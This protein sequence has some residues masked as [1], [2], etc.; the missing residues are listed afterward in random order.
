LSFSD[1]C[2]ELLSKVPSGQITTYKAIATALNSKAYRAVGTVMAKNKNLI[3]VPCH[4]VINN[5]GK[6]GQYALGI[7]KK[8][9]LLENEGIRIR[10]GK[11]EEFEKHLYSF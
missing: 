1:D 6:I 7:N 5:N 3:V 9:L 8:I 2:Y 10:N 11:V 4:R